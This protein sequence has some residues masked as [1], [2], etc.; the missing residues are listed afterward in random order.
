MDDER[1]VALLGSKH[2]VGVSWLGIEGGGFWG[3][4]LRGRK[5]REL[6]SLR[7][8]LVEE[9]GEEETEVYS[10]LWDSGEVAGVKY[11]WWYICG[12]GGRITTP[13]GWYC[14]GVYS[15]SNQAWNQK[16]AQGSPNMNDTSG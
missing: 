15:G 16:A 1:G 4:G 2:G 7:G 14:Y 13:S 8:I 11:N 5:G 9:E 12:C 3:R 6:R 10:L